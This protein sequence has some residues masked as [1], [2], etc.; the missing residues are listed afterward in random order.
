M[1]VISSTLACKENEFSNVGI[2]YR[3][4]NETK[5]KHTISKS[6]WEDM[7]WFG[8]PNEPKS[9]VEVRGSS[10]STLALPLLRGFLGMEVNL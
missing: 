5:T 1:R 4:G 3:K 8:R 2:V 10:M 7:S 9:S 6:N